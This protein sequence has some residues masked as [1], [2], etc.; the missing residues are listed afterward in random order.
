MSESCCDIPEANT[1][2][3]DFCP[4]C[5]EKGKPVGAITINALVRPGLKSGSGFPDGYYCPNPDDDTLYFF[6][7]GFD[8]ISK[9]EISVRVGF[10]ETAAP[11][12]VCYCYEHTKDEI[13]EDF[14]ANGESR[15]EAR[16][17]EEVTADSCSCQFKNPKGNCCLG[18][19]RAAYKELNVPLAI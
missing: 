3:T 7:S 5:G 8:P 17:R 6:D 19:V 4:T 12:M 15:I 16:I 2:G 9:A 11:Q 18:D 14:E 13:Q 10:K 1:S